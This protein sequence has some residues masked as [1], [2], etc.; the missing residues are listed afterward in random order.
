MKGFKKRIGL[1]FKIYLSIYLLL[2]QVATTS[3]ELH[4]FLHT[5]TFEKCCS[6]TATNQNIFDIEHKNH[7]CAVTLLALGITPTL[8]FNYDFALQDICRYVSLEHKLYIN[9]K[10]N[11]NFN[12]RDPPQILFT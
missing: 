5:A 9:F 8:V 2:L 3:P 6:D 10:A 4:Q 7:Q 12:P 1:I 11:K